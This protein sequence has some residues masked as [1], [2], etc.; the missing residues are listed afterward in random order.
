[1]NET[2]DPE[3]SPKEPP[4]ETKGPSLPAGCLSIVLAVLLLVFVGWFIVA[5][6]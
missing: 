5:W 4:K 1:M 2:P 6:R 3:E